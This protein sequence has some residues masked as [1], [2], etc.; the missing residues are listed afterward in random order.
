MT[1]QEVAPAEKADWTGF[2]N[3]MPVARQ[4]AY[5]DHAAVAPLSGPAQRAIARWNEDSAANGDAFYP[6][7]MRQLNEARQRSAQ[8]LNAQP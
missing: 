8:L 6:G 4:W 7:W 1:Q 3:E 5:F 2:R